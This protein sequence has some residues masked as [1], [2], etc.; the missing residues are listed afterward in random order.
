[1][2]EQFPRLAFVDLETTGAT[3]SADR[4]T[5]IG[6][7]EV[8]ADGVR[9]WSSLVNPEARIPEFIER[10]TG[11]SN[12][13]VA[14]A[15]TFAHLVAEVLPRLRDRLFVAH[16][17]RFDYG[18]LQ[19]EFGR[20]GIDFHARVLC[21][22]RLSRRL[23]P[24]FHKHSLD[25][26]IERHALRVDARHRAL[27][28]AQLIWQFWQRLHAEHEPAV[29]AG[30]VTALVARPAL[31][32][33]LDGE[34]ADRLPERCGIYIFHGENDVPL[35]IGKH[36]N[37]RQGVLAHFSSERSSAGN[38]ALAS[39]VRRVEWQETSGELATQLKHALLIRQFRPSGNP[40]SASAGELCSWRLSEGGAGLL[41]PTLVTTAEADFGGD[42]ALYG[43]FKH[44]REARKVLTALVGEHRLCPALLGLERHVPGR[45]C[46]AQAARKCRGACI[47]KEELS[48]H[49][50]RLLAALASQR[51]R[52]WPFAGPAGVREGEVLHVVDRWRY[53]GVA[54]SDDEVWPLLELRR[55]DFDA[56]IYRILLKVAGRMLPLPFSGRS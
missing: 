33:Q 14:S 45:A 39:Q 9:E 50:A 40:R 49:S 30:A 28:D 8:D 36:K 24:Q 5:E 1:M 44:A 12:E 7:V 27:A 31:P 10:L 56:D 48:V 17:A 3:A 16:N 21:T 32:P 51:V 38:K 4:I 20:L 53:L 46:S 22:V 6:I 23:Y 42:E 29:I 41:Q 13:M 35:Y 18:F 47:G 11:I 43:L 55:P 52:S 26:L 25:A 54:R 37:L 34:L 19:S 2:I 15:P